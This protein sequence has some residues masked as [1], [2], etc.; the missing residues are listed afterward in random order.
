MQVS[1]WKEGKMKKHLQE[2]EDDAEDLFH[3][4]S[5]ETITLGPGC[6]CETG[7]GCP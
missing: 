6:S 5:V 3:Q 7:L 4:G 2:S 1:K